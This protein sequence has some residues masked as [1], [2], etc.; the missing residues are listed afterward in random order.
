MVIVLRTLSLAAHLLGVLRSVLVTFWAKAIYKHLRFPWVLRLRFRQLL[1]SVRPRPRPLWGIADCHFVCINLDN[2]PDRLQATEIEFEQMG[3]EKPERFA[4]VRRDNGMLGAAMSH[5]KV[6]KMLSERKGG[7]PS[8]VLED[9]VE[10]LVDRREVEALFLEFMEADYLDVLCLGNMIKNTVYEDISPPL[11]ISDELLVSNEVVTQ[12]FYV[13]KPR[14]LAVLA[15]SMDKSVQLLSRG[16]QWR[17]AA[18][19]VLWQ[20]VQQGRLIF[21]VPRKRVLRQRAGYS[22]IWSHHR[23]FPF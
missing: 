4:A 16:V 3:L 8:V 14:A 10:F 1:A 12:S 21:A 19:D 2:R 15:K 17:Y 5:S 23:D 11:R 18:G 6:L 13:V 20:Q 22:D 7:A 9:D